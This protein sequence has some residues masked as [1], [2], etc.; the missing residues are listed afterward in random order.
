MKQL[1]AGS[2]VSQE[3]PRR[4]RSNRRHWPAHA[5]RSDAAS[6][7]MTGCEAA[8]PTAGESHAGPRRSRR[9]PFSCVRPSISSRDA[10][11]RIPA[12]AGPARAR[13]VAAGDP[14]AADDRLRRR[15]RR[16]T[17]PG[18]P[19]RGRKPGRRRHAP[20]GTVCRARSS[21]RSRRCRPRYGL[22]AG[23]LLLFLAYP[24]A[25]E[26]LGFL[27]ATFLL[28]ALFMLVGQW[29]NLP[30]R[31][32]CQRRRHPGPVLHL[33][34]RRLRLAAAGQRCR[35]TTATV[36]VAGLLGMR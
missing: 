36:W 6:A 14:G 11:V 12:R 24:V 8:S 10:A 33:P 19:A 21:R 35:S 3:P 17:F 34:R 5:E 25:L 23:G 13:R 28:M 27:V 16:A 31:A 9:S 4:R 20:P 2:G 15:H 26:Y 22:V 30:G 1:I 18:R 7:G 29:R 32:G